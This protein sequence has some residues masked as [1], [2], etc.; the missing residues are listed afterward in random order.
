MPERSVLTDELVTQLIAVGEV[1]ALVALPTFHDG[2]AAATAARAAVIGLARRFPRART[3]FLHVDGGPPDGTRDAVLRA[4]GADLEPEI[5][6]RSLRTIHRISAPYDGLPTRATALRAIFAS[7]DLL[8]ARAVAVLDPAVTS[9]EPEWIGALLGPVLENGRDFVAPVHARHPLDAPLVSQLV[10]PLVRAVYARRVREPIAGEFACSGGF[11]AF[12]LA[13]RIWDREMA[14]YGVDLALCLVALAEPFAV[15]QTALGPRVVAPGAPRPALADAFRQVVGT[16]LACVEAHHRA[17]SGRVEAEEVPMVGEPPAL[18]EATIAAEGAPL[19]EGFR[20]GLKDVGDLYQPILDA[21]TLAAIREAAAADGDAF[22]FDDSVWAATVCQFA[23]AYH[24]QTIHRD[25]IVQALVPLYLGRAASFL[26]E[27][28]ERDG[29]AVEARVEA[30]A[31]RFEAMRP[32]F[33][34]EWDPATGGER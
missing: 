9:V 13:E 3:A 12:C 14:P 4:V 19:L 31:R 15:A 25:H 2:E 32:Q 16:A 5:A 21:P 7:A 8:Q 6:T 26:L 27:C 17:W 29:A 10:R 22:R 23:V 1:D 11:A 30:L 18:P 24:R 33:L 34:R 28:A 20:A